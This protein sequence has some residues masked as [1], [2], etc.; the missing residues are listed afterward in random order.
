MS[1]LP[2]PATI[3]NVLRRLACLGALALVAT[4]CTEKPR[5]DPSNA[6]QVAR[7]KRV[8]EAQCAVC[9]GAQLEGQPNWRERLPSGRFPAPPHDPSGHTWHHSDALLFSITK[10]G[11]ERHA[12]PG[13][14]SDMPAFGK[15]LSDDEIWAV[16][17]YIKSTWPE[18]TRKWQAEVSQEDARARR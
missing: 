2:C 15:Q 1:S 13:Y 6:E 10:H 3:A 5:A 16:L 12:P 18:E 7:G 8:Y 4:A 17:A 14:E 9:H 11:I